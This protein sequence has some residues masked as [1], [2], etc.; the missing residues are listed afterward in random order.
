MALSRESRV[1]LHIHSNA[2]DGTHS[3][4]EL[5]QEAVENN[6]GLMALTDHDEIENIE[7]V[8]SLTKEKGIAFLPGIEISSTFQDK[9]YH[10]LAYGTDNGN[11]ELMKL[12][13][14]NK[15]MLN[16]RNDDSIKYLIEKG[17]E[18]DLSEYEKYE[19]DK[20]KG[21]WKSLSFLIEKGI[22]RDVGDYFNRLFYKQKTILFPEFSSTEIVVRT[23]K[24]AGGIPILA[25]PYYEKDN[26][27]IPEKLSRFIDIGI[28][29]VE[30]FHP[31]HS[32]DIINKCLEWCKAKGIIITAGSDFHGGFIET[33]RMGIPEAKIKDINLG[34]LESK[35]IY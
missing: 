11:K 34:D 22:C 14:H 29:G 12:I 28:E 33:R 23:I 30:C 26:T 21:G 6:I 2:S 15:H 35:I 8:K 7:E 10:I 4:K 19:Y 31:N 3:P 17:Y 32:Y 18:I 16:K 13:D 20:R 9:L 25:H 5:V 1:D 27:S 24:N